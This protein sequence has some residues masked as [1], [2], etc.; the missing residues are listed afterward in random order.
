MGSRHVE[1]Y[2]KG[3]YNIYRF[4]PNQGMSN[5]WKGIIE[6]A[7]VLCEGMQVAVSNGLRTL[8][9]D[10]KWETETSLSNLAT[11]AKPDE[12]LDARVS[13]ML[14]SLQGWESESFIEYLPPDALEQ[15][16]SFEF[17]ENQEIGDLLYWSSGKKKKFSIKS[18]LSIM[19]NISDSLDDECWNL[20]WTIPIQQHI[21]AF[22]WMAHHSRI[23]G[24]LMRFKHKMNEDTT[25]YICGAE[26][27]STL[28]I[29]M[30]CPTSRM[31]K[32]M[33][34]GTLYI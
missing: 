14:D 11:Q 18:S 6:N 23:L 21:R 29:L 30:N 19:R 24:N 28:H 22:L 20:I 9:W 10:H 31:I 7:K 8:F 5:D 4:T 12:F 16:Q 13:N 27:E 15:I 34:G 32:S 1:W 26:E 33:L 17:K 2:C 25:C 3:R